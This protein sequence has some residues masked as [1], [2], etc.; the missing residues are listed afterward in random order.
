MEQNIPTETTGK[1]EAFIEWLKSLWDKVDIKQWAEDI[2]GSSSEAVQAA[3]YFGLGFAFGFLF[4]KYFKFVFFSLLVAIVL[5]LVLQYNRVLDID[6]KAL[7]VLLGFEPSA[8]I[9][10]V[11]NSMFDWIKQNLI[12]FISSTVGFLIGYKLG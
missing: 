11:L 3:I 6:W 5:I 4:K 1:F 12:I 10:V 7:N 2:G 8:D 9:G